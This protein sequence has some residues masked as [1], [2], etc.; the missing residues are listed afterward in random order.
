[1]AFE[2]QTAPPIRAAQYIRMSTEHQLYSLENKAM[3]IR[4][5]AE[6]RGYTIVQTYE[7]AGKSGLSIRGRDGLKQLLAD[8]MTG[9]KTFSAILVLDVSRWGAF[10]IRT[11]PLITSL[12][13][14]MQASRWNI[15][16]KNSRTTAAWSLQS[17][18]P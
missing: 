5:Y 3:A 14:V 1:M 7:D 8:V 10:R 11:S 13:V 4:E 9:Q 2:L 18:R 15:A 16:A 17:S 12:S 6:R